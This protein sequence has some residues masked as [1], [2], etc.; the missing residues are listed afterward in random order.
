MAMFNSY[1]KLPEGRLVGGIPTPL[2]NMS[3]SIGM[4]IPFPTEWENKKIMFQSPPTSYLDDC[5]P[6]KFHHYS[7]YTIL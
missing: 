2:K 1:A 6:S 7:Y 3:S 4:I 5:I